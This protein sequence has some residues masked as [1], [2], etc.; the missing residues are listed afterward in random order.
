MSTIEEAREVVINLCNSIKNKNW[1]GF[2]SCFNT[3]DRNWKFVDVLPDG[4]IVE[5][6]Q[7]LIDLHP[8]FFQSKRTKFLP[9]SGD[10]EF[11]HSNFLYELSQGNVCQFAVSA[12]ITKPKELSGVL[13]DETIPLVSIKNILAFTIAFDEKSN[14]WWPMSITNTVV[15]GA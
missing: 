11:K 1:E 8:F 2:V 7:E 4:K 12:N 3:A 5:G 13:E 6:S 9:S 10:M 15:G 14:R